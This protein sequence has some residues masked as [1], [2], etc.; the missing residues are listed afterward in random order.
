MAVA[1]AEKVL[2]GAAQA[3]M[4]VAGG[5]GSDAISAT[6]MPLLLMPSATCP[7]CL[8]ALCLSAKLDGP[9]APKALRTGCQRALDDGDGHRTAFVT[10]Q[11]RLSLQSGLGNDSNAASVAAARRGTRLMSLASSHFESALQAADA[12]AEECRGGSSAET[13]QSDIAKAQLNCVAMRLDFVKYALQMQ[14][15]CPTPTTRV[16][17]LLASLGRLLQARNAFGDLQRDAGRMLWPVVV[18]SLRKLLKELVSIDHLGQGQGQGETQAQEQGQGQGRRTRHQV[19]RECYRITAASCQ[20]IQD[21]CSGCSRTHWAKQ[22]CCQ[23][24]MILILMLI[25][26]LMR[27]HK[28]ALCHLP[29]CF[30]CFSV[31]TCSMYSTCKM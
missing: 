8:V 20:I 31:P 29:W 25:L 3:A 9:R 14:A 6:P 7:A 27:I 5:G 12:A 26:T 18:E 22:S 10:H 1:A 30:N 24:G 13:T 4:S 11:H 19:V 17:L 28:A 21:S 15:H 16:K 2:L 23:S